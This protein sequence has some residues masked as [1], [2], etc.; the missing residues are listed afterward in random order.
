MEKE[1]EIIK[2]IDLMDQYVGK[3]CRVFLADGRK[4]VAKLA[5]IEGS[6]LYFQVRDGRYIMNRRGSIASITP[7]LVQ[8][9]AT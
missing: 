2:E 7:L 8:P 6:E 1:I 4:F 5:K 9:E 3:V